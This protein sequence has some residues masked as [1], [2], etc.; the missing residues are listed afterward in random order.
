MVP[1]EVISSWV[2][3]YS[4]Y[5]WCPLQQSILEMS[6]QVAFAGWNCIIPYKY[7]NW[8]PSAFLLEQQK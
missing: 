7:H 5:T 2:E 4:S 3:I 8:I 6:L 1:K